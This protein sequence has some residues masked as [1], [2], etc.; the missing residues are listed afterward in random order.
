MNGG[1][2]ERSDE[3]CLYLDVFVPE[4]EGGRRGGREGRLPVLV[5][6]H[7]GGYTSG[8]GISGWYGPLFY[9][10]H[11]VVL[12]E[13]RYRLGP[14]GFLSLGTQDVPGNAGV[15]DQLAALTWV[16]DNIERFGGDPHLVTVYGQSAGSFASTYH[17]MS[18]LARSVQTFSPHIS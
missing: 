12:V 13:V 3:D 17:I 7:G 2:D 9:I 6:I 4:V 14:L 11:E 15:R 16:Q 1:L 8:A 10:S 18:P 5:W